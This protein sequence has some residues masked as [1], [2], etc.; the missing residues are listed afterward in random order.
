MALT[1]TWTYWADLSHKTEIS[2]ETISTLAEQPGGGAFYA[3]H[4][5]HLVHCLF[6]RR[7]SM[8]A[9]SSGVRVEGRY[10][11][12]K[13]VIHCTKMLDAYSSRGSSSVVALNSNR[14]L[15]S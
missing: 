12:E 13:H 5:W 15:G 6:Y 7:K 14:F 1:E 11:T 9:A 10:N 4:R 8:R 3:T 2:V